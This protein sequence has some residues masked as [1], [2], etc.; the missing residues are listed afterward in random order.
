MAYSNQTTNYGLPLPN[1]T[2][3]STWLDTNEGFQA[4]D[5][6]LAGAVAKGSANESAI[7]TLKT[8]VAAN[9]TNIATNSGNIAALDTR[10]TANEQV[11]SN[12]LQSVA[13]LSEKVYDYEEKTFTNAAEAYAYLGT[14]IDKKLSPHVIVKTMTVEKATNGLFAY[15]RTNTGAA[16]GSYTD[17]NAAT[18]ELYMRAISPYKFTCTEII[19]DFN[20]GVFSNLDLVLLSA[21]ITQ[22]SMEYRVREQRL[23]NDGE[24]LISGKSTI[25]S[26]TFLVPV[27]VA[28]D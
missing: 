22:N 2:D 23:R 6:A 11:A 3:K 19:G 20:P 4:I 16:T 17:Y 9:E 12:A 1:G 26:I 7:T 15:F 24:E 18:F 27:A 13:Q 25:S 5:T 28:D 10:L 14:L 8:R 21:D